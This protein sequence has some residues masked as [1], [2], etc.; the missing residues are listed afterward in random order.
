MK[1]VKKKNKILKA[2]IYYYLC[3]VLWDETENMLR[4]SKS[5]DKKQMPYTLIVLYG[6]KENKL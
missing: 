4:K 5:N 6:S 3:K 2:T 1:K